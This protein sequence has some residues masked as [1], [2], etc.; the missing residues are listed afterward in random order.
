MLGHWFL[1]LTFMIILGFYFQLGILGF[2]YSKLALE[3]F[4]NTAYLTILTQADWELISKNAVK[5]I[6]N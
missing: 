5:N 2:W 4:L 1:N 6:K 3:L